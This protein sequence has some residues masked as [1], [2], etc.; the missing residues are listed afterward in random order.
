LHRDHTLGAKLLS[1]LVNAH[2][3]PLLGAQQ[4]FSKLI[5]MSGSPFKADIAFDAAE[6]S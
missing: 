4:T 5:V 6:V 1:G 2:Q 3:C